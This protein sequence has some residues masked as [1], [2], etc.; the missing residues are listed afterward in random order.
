[1]SRQVWAFISRNHALFLALLV[2]FEPGFAGG[3]G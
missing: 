1:M 2:L 3:C